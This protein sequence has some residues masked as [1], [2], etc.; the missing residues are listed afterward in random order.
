[1]P[2]ATASGMFGIAEGAVPLFASGVSGA[3]EAKDLQNK[4]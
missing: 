4:S 1:L 2:T 3:N